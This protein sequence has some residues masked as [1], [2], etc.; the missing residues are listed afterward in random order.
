MVRLLRIRFDNEVQACGQTYSRALILINLDEAQRSVSQK[1]LA[2]MMYVEE[3]TVARLVEGLERSGLV[4]R[5]QGVVDRR[6]KLVS[7]TEAAKP[8]ALEAK[9]RLRRVNAE[10]MAG[11]PPEQLTIALSVLQQIREGLESSLTGPV[12]KAVW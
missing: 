8:I 7:L 1:E 4:T 12:V 2:Q 3:P 11:I 9:E 5:E 6:V 10:V